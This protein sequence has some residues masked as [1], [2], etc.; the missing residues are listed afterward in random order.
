MNGRLVSA[1]SVPQ[2]KHINKSDQVIDERNLHDTLHFHFLM[3]LKMRIRVE[4]ESR[5]KRTFGDEIWDEVLFLRN[6]GMY[7]WKTLAI[8]RKITPGR[9]CMTRHKRWLLGALGR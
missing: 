5:K 1:V 8:R 7:L 4:W 2:D 6:S 3:G 9:W